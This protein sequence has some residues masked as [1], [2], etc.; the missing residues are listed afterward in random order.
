MEVN[1]QSTSSKF[2][3]FTFTV[4][5]VYEPSYNYWLYSARF[6]IN[7]SLSTCSIDRIYLVHV[8]VGHRYVIWAETQARY[9]SPNQ[10]QSRKSQN[11]LAEHVC[12]RSAVNIVQTVSLIYINQVRALTGHYPPL[13]YQ[14][15]N[16]LT[17]LSVAPESGHQTMVIGQCC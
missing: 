8:K 3:I 11:Y 2:L 13:F 4:H 17:V 12:R 7:F 15:V 14:H 9:L 6:R 5:L 1:F 16:I 10:S